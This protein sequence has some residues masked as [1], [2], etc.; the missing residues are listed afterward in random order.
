MGLI[1]SF[2]KWILEEVFKREEKFRRCCKRWDLYGD[3]CLSKVRTK[4]LRHTHHKYQNFEQINA[5]ELGS[6]KRKGHG[7]EGKHLMG[8]GLGKPIKFWGIKGDKYT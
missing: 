7:R 2:S 4:R 3:Q 5:T 6:G 1:L 8:E